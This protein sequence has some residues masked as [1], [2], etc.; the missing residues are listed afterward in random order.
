[1]MVVIYRSSVRVCKGLE[2]AEMTCCGPFEKRVTQIFDVFKREISISA[3]PE[4]QRSASD[5]LRLQYGE[6]YPGS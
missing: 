6:E 4:V 3:R 2:R 1:M 5:A